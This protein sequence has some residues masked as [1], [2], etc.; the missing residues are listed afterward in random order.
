[1]RRNRIA[2]VMAAL[3]LGMPQAVAGY[4][5]P[6]AGLTII[7]AALAFVGAVVLGLI[8]FVWYPVKQLKR[9]WSERKET[10]VQGG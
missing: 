2:F 8:G 3:L 4:V 9:A 6:G 7:G 5:G 10:P 1:M